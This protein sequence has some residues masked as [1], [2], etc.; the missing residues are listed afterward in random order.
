MLPG[1]QGA[2]VGHDRTVQ[3]RQ[4][5]RQVGHRVV[6]LRHVPAHLRQHSIMQQIFF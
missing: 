3:R 2:P 5:H 1:L 4:D 6:E